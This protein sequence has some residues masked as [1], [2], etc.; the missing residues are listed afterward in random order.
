[1]NEN[2]SIVNK[3]NLKGSILSIDKINGAVAVVTQAYQAFKIDIETIQIKNLTTLINSEQ[4]PHKYA[5][6]SSASDDFICLGEVGSKIISIA[7]IAESIKIFLKL[8]SHKSDI[9]ASC[10]SKDGHYLASGGEDGRVHLYETNNFRKIFSLPYRPDYIS[11]L[12]F[13][14]DSRFLFASCFNK[15]NMI[16]DCQ[17]AKT[18]GI[19]NTNEVV[20]W[21][22]FFDN[23]AKLFMILR[24]LNSIIYDTR[25]NQVL[26][27]SSPF[28]SWPS[29]FCINDKEDMAIVGS[30][31]SNIYII[32]L[33]EN[34]KIFSLKLEN[35]TG[36]SALCVHLGYIFI[37]YTNGELAVIN[38]DDKNDEFK[39]A[40]ENKDYKKAAS[41]LDK[42]IFL[43]LLPCVKIFD[44][45]W[46][47]ILKEAIE[48]LAQDKIDEALELVDPFTRDISKKDI[49][50]FYLN[51]KDVLKK[52]QELIKNRLYEEAY[53]MT[54]QT[55]FLTKT[56]HFEMLENTWHKS[57]NA[58]KKL[59]EE[60]PANVEA[61]KKYLELFLK[62]PK[63]EAIM[64]LLNNLHIFKD[65]ENFVKEQK[66]KDY[67]A[68]TSNFGY[69]RETE[70]YKKVLMLGENLFEKVIFYENKNDY[71]EFHK[72][73]KFLQSF[74]SYKESISTHIVAV[75]K[76]RE[77]LNLI[78][79]NKKYDVY[80][81]A[82]EFEELQYLDEFKEF[83]KE[84]NEIYQEAREIAFNGTPEALE[85]IFKDYIRINYWFDKIE[86]TFKIAYL[87]EFNNKIKSQA[88][89][90]WE[91]SI[92]R[93][94]NIFGKDD[95]IV[96]FCVKNNFQQF[97]D[98]DDENITREPFRFQKTLI[99]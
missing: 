13:S 22:D 86:H 61:A 28:T 62:T 24:N 51:K 64:Q 3:F 2:I 52:F 36:I 30:R 68:L 54:L 73:A 69:L 82:I 43:S 87:E 78:K 98:I 97:I 45:D 49:F 81:L 93:Y 74:P 56:S 53:N 20:E 16:F 4:L 1:M 15:S 91:L 5:N 89:V 85:D 50:N 59:L 94:I 70:L 14:K 57:F 77:M 75:A 67:F 37:G 10:F 33:T 96:G 31:D 47:E 44:E 29:I 12:N 79:Q 18:I 38:Y 55:K 39:I 34:V 11:S 9:S 8:K 71:D 7:R 65:A 95:D 99:Q 32:N 6:S 58:A 40:C 26:N 84:F 63:K 42:N 90:N 27:I 66:F 35:T 72:L 25:T 48:L 17:R 41:M 19:F 60:D 21:G 88:S 92:R 23:N 46:D 83:C 76:K 80:K